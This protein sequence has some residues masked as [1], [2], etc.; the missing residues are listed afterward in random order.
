MSCQLEVTEENGEV[1]GVEGADCKVGLKYAE[2]EFKDPRRVVTTTVP[3]R[4]GLLPLLPVR[5][6]A[7]IPKRLILDAARQLANVVVDAP[8]KG[9]QVIMGDIMGT[10][11]D[12]ISSRDLEASGGETGKAGAA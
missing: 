12:V 2:E 11:V 10:G 4:H 8:V 6:T 7:P 3:V 1:T 9:G 5:S